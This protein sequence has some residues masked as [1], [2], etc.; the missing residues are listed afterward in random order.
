MAHP[1]KKPPTS[2]NFVTNTIQIITKSP[3]KHSQFNKP[4]I[5]KKK[6]KLIVTYQKP[7][8]EVKKDRAVF[9]TKTLQLQIKINAKAYNRSEGI[10]IFDY[11]K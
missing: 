1:T 8:N 5:F 9:P 6:C 4:K 7:N 10:E 11:A 2:V 3:D